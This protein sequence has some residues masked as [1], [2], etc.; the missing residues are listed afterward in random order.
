MSFMEGRLGT[1]LQ[2]QLRCFLRGVRNRISKETYSHLKFSRGVLP[3][4][5]LPL[6]NMFSLLNYI[7]DTGKLC[8]TLANSEDL[9]EMLQK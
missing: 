8:G 9:D 3:P 4:M 1:S 7:L 6:Q 2:K 5:D